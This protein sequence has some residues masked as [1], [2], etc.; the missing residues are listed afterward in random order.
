MSFWWQ[1]KHSYPF[2]LPSSSA[3][4]WYPLQDTFPVCSHAVFENQWFSVLSLIFPSLPLQGLSYFPSRAFF[5]AW[6]SIKL[7][8][9]SRSCFICG[10][11]PP[12][13]PLLH[14]RSTSPTLRTTVPSK[15]LLSGLLLLPS[16][17]FVCPWIHQAGIATGRVG[18][19][20]WSKFMI[21]F[22]SQ[23]LYELWGLLGGMGRWSFLSHVRWVRERI[24]IVSFFLFW[25]VSQSKS[26]VRLNYC[27]FRLWYGQ[28]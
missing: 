24:F 19:D 15:I 6:A 16:H 17:S 2:P 3:T 12:L 28:V 8:A 11:P 1:Q 9:R 5:P 21:F 25:V 23:S 13:P 22:P 27:S 7:A 26:E 18:C 14:P 4:W 20:Q 10:D